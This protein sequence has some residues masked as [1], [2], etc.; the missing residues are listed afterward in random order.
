LS[1]HFE[2]ERSRRIIGRGGRGK[3]RRTVLSE[4]NNN[5]NKKKKKSQGEN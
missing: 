2:G 4:F 3:K 1:R 5:N